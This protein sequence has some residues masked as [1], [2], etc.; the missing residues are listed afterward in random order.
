M[1]RLKTTHNQ[2]HLNSGIHLY[3]IR[4]CAVWFR[5]A[6]LLLL[7]KL[8]KGQFNSK[9][10][11]YSVHTLTLFSRK[12]TPNKYQFLYVREDNQRPSKPRLIY[13]TLELTDTR[14]P[15]L[16]PRGGVLPIVGHTGRLHLKGGGPPLAR[17]AEITTRNTRNL[18]TFEQLNLGN[19]KPRG[20]SGD[21]V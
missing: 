5:L 8:H 16:V 17:L 12:Q 3:R 13:I 4:K 20:K 2:K 21:H 15:Q 1:S 11:S 14:K 9:R 7:C 19:W 10:H 6:F 18:G